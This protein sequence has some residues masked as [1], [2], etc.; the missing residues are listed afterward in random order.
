M[1][2]RVYFIFFAMVLFLVTV[3]PMGT[4]KGKE[5]LNSSAYIEVG[6]DNIACVPAETEF[7][8]YNGTVMRVIDVI[9]LSENIE[10]RPPEGDC[11]CPNCCGGACA[12]II[13]C[14]NKGT[15]GLC[16]MFLTC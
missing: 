10:M 7:V 13:N 9:P 14:T 5:A 11:F 16:V 4:K 2:K 6:G 3:Y 15:R 1:K 12:V 8:T